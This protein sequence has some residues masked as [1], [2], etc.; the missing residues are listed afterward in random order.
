[1]AGAAPLV[2]GAHAVQLDGGSG[3]DRRPSGYGRPNGIRGDSR[4]RR[5]PERSDRGAADTLVPVDGSTRVGKAQFGCRLQPPVTTACRARSPAGL[6]GSELRLNQ[7]P[8]NQPAGEL[9]TIDGGG[10]PSVASLRR[11]CTG[12]LAAFPLRGRNS[13]DLFHVKHSRAHVGAE[14]AG[15][16]PQ[17]CQRSESRALHRDTDSTRIAV[18]EGGGLA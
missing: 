4:T 17:V 12:Y 13:V 1:M 15:W 18:I 3:P 9:R 16:K 10:A 6:S 2:L 5:A 11:G 14:E 8:S 7:H